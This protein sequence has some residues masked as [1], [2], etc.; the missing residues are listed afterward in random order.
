M[1]PGGT[2]DL[3]SARTPVVP[4]ASRASVLGALREM[5]MRAPSTH[6]RAARQVAIRWQR[7]QSRI[8]GLY[9]QRV[10]QPLQLWH[11]FGCPSQFRPSLPWWQQFVY[12]WLVVT[13]WVRP[14][15]R[16]RQV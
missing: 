11:A 8:A 7:L 14:A 10:T 6:T 12:S 5:V 4:A 9:F 13:G 1:D 2:A 16:Q 3:Y 15:R